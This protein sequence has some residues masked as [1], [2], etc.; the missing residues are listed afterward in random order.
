MRKPTGWVALHRKIWKSD[1]WKSKKPFDERSAWVDLLLMAEFADGAKA[2]R[3]QI[4]T[5]YGELADRWHWS[6]SRVHRFI[7]NLEADKCIKISP[8]KSGTA[9]G[10]ASGTVLTIEKYAVYQD[11]W[12]GKR[13]EKRKHNNNINNIRAPGRVGTLPARTDEDEPDPPIFT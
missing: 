13:N 5:S 9:N 7:H 2:K 4:L 3:G 11:V 8:S 10:T 1:V 12:N 6:K